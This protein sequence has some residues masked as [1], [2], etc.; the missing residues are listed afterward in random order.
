V[1]G[2]D[3]GETTPD[4][5]LAATRTIASAPSG[6]E[7]SGNPTGARKYTSTTSQSACR[8]AGRLAA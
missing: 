1:A 8:V 2:S 7:N 6:I 5:G 4:G 3:G